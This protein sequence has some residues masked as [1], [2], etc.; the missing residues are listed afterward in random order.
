MA[1][2]DVTCPKELCVAASTPVKSVVFT[3]EYCTVLKTLLAV[4]RTSKLRVSPSCMVFDRDILFCTIP[5]PGIRFREALPKAF[6]R[7]SGVGAVKA[8]VLNQRF[9][10]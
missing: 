6:P 8:A 3:P 10:E 5:G 4:A 1:A 9:R 2:T 7:L